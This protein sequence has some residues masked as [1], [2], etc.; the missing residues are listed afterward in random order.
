MEKESLAG[1]IVVAEGRCNARMGRK[2]GE[3]RRKMV[4]MSEVLSGRIGE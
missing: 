3:E 1:E 2:G 4:V